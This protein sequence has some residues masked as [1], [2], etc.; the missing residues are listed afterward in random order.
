[1]KLFYPTILIIPTSISASRN[2]HFQTH[3]PAFSLPVGIASSAKDE[4]LSFSKQQFAESKTGVF[5]SDYES[6]QQLKKL[7]AELE[8]VCDPPTEA[9]QDL[10]LG[11][12]KLLCTIATPTDDISSRL[13]ANRKMK[14]TKKGLFGL[15][16]P[17]PPEFLKDTLDPIQDNLRQSVEVIQ[18]IRKVEDFDGD[19]DTDVLNR[20]DNVIQF[21]PFSMEN[22]LNGANLNLNPLEVTKSKVSLVHSAKVQSVSPLLRTK[23]V[24]KSYVCKYN[25]PKCVEIQILLCGKKSHEKD[26]QSSLA[27]YTIDQ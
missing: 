1:M 19:S 11:D 20:V 9:S 23:L 17:S 3:T 13:P 18:R 26:K 14:K 25:T 10:M 24:L 8:A 22:I 2:N 27:L 5:L 15:P 21:T 4:L 16:L 12:W 7:T 6:K